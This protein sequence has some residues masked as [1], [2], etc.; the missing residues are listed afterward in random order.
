MDLGE[1]I[2]HRLGAFDSRFGFSSPRFWSAAQPFDFAMDAICERFLP[3]ALSLEI[4]FL[5]F[6]KV[7]VVSFTRSKPCS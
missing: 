7:A 6:Q 4:S 5:R 3:L 1:F 2:D